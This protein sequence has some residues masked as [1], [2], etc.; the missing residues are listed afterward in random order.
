MLLVFRMVQSTGEAMVSPLVVAIPTTFLPAGMRGRALGFIALA[1][2][3][4]FAL[5]NVVGGFITA[6][7]VWRAV[8][9][10]NIPIALGLIAASLK[11]VPSEQPR[12][13]ERTFDLA[14]SVLIF[15]ALASL[16]L[17]LNLMVKKGTAPAAITGSFAVSAAV[18]TLF[19]LQ[20][21]RS[22]SPVL[23]FNLF[24]NR[25]FTFA[26]LAVFFVLFIL[27][28]Y[29]F[30]A[31]FYLEIVC[32]LDVARAGALLMMPSA[33]MLI[34]APFTGRL[35]DRIGSR[36]LCSAGSALLVASCAAFGLLK[37]DSG[38]SHAAAALILLGIA[39]GIFMA[40]NNKLVMA[41]AP[42]DKQGVASGV[43]KIGVSIGSV[44]GIAVLPVVI[45]RASAAEAGRTQFA[46]SAARDNPSIIHAGFHAAFLIGVF[47]A[48]AAFACSILAK[49]KI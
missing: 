2:G 34:L 41:H 21:R 9:L 30:I 17:G 35:S 15:V 8:F 23:D 4:G 24:K 18:F 1:Q 38:I 37:A 39:A 16:L 33:M 19:I 46:L 44:F 26:L 40:P 43:Y 29:S 36:L 45:M 25:D 10:V 27:M 14:G 47:I 6:H 32:R 13:S 31:P 49:D 11:G 12:P 42:D 7:L 28:G 3:A 20:E 22:V 5:G 48:L